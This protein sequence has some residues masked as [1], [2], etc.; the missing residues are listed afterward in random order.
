M[1]WWN[2]RQSLASFQRLAE[3]NA[4]FVG[5]LRL[6]K[7]PELA[8]RLATILNTGVGFYFE[9]G[10]ANDW[11]P[12]LHDA[13]VLLAVESPGTMRAS[14]FELAMAPLP[15]GSAQL[16]LV[17]DASGLG[18]NF[19]SVLAPAFLIAAAGGILA[20]LLGRRVVRPIRDLTLW[21]PNLDL[22][23]STNREPVPTAILERGDEI[24]RLANAIGDTAERLS[25]EQQL[26]RQSERLATLGRIATGLAHEIKNPAAAIA[27]HADL[28]R[29]HDGGESAELIHEEVERITDLVNQWL[30]VARSK[31]GKTTPH[32]LR[33]LLEKVSHRLKPQLDHSRV[34]LRIDAESA[35]IKADAPRIE[36]TLRNLLL[37]AVQAMPMGGEIRA[38]LSVCEGV[39]KLEIEDDGPGFSEEAERRFGEPFF[40]E[41]EGGMGIGLT[42]AREVVQ[43]HGG[44]I[45]PSRSASGGACITVEIPQNSS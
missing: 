7:S 15:D 19:S 3:T 38:R 17:R 21:L 26:R 36:Q 4:A 42:L 41:R 22:A 39:V 45:A 30:F 10:E 29:Q 23:S 35:M 34:S 20:I 11:P 25:E 16:L 13:I 18:A 6:P 5:Q 32:D 40:S 8:E 9:D 27:M 1:A 14:G 28:L 24:G 43:A 33:Q 37:N 44:S 31:P 2:Q 12:E